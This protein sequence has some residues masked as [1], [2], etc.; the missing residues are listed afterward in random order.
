MK[1]HDVHN[2]EYIIVFQ[3]I[4][5]EQC[6]MPTEGGGSHPELVFG[7]VGP[8]GA[9]LHTVSTELS[10]ALKH[11]G[12]HP[13]S[14]RLSQLMRAIPA[15][16]WATLP[17]NGPADVSLG[18]YMTAGNGL[19]Q[20]LERGDALALM[21]VGAIREYRA[22][23]TGDPNNPCT[24][25]AYLLHSLKRPE[26]A[27]AL[28]RIYGPTFFL[29][30]AYAPRPKRV[31]NVSHRIAV[32][33]FAHQAEDFTAKAE[34]LI[35]R[36]ESEADTKLGQNVLD[37]FPLA[38]VIVNTADLRATRD[39][40]VRFI[41]LIFGNP[42][43]TPTKDEQ[44]VKFA[45]IAAC[46]SASLARQVGAAICRDDG[47]VIAI[48]A[49]EVPKANGGQYW[50][51]DVLDAR[52]FYLQRDSSDR[53]RE[54]LLGDV[55]ERLQKAGWLRRD[56]GRRA[57]SRLVDEC[58]NLGDRPIMKGAIFLRTIDYV[59]AVHA[60][61][62][63]LTEAARHGISTAGATLYTTTY[64]CHDCAKHI[65]SAGIK[66]VVYVEPYPKSLVQE[67][68]ADSVAVDQGD[69]SES[70]VRFESF[71]GIAPGRYDQLFALHG[72]SRKSKSGMVTAWRSNAAKPILSDFN[73][74][75][76]PIIRGEQV[77]FNRF[78]EGMIQKGLTKQGKGKN[79]T[80]KGLA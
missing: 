3:N 25:T 29:V 69:V 70:K 6:F 61:M 71:V 16:P 67:L 47:S 77:A 15:E 28:R 55:L 44:A 1:N 60:E 73:M 42:F 75:T 4:W 58:L 10:E 17:E 53:M 26:E 63:A 66:R 64:P 7:V 62:A 8:L 38:D 31:Q 79:G 22:S 37:T 12:Y 65:V 23:S 74:A 57:L 68:Y 20:T 72:K 41:E 13:E 21:G 34:E 51:G 78:R 24:K 39:A 9:D 19:R 36:D 33:K 48:G 11:V 43:H 40:L 80:K 49:N 18:A 27:H 76:A 2:G 56:M 52:D 45:F 14:V 46:R 59:R 50:T 30:A 35:R 32:S 54:A 5:T